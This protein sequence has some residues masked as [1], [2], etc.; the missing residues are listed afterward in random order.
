MRA[1]WSGIR[2][3]PWPMPPESVRGLKS[4]SAVQMSEGARASYS[5]NSCAILS[6]EYMIVSLRMGYHFTTVEAMCTEE[7]G[8]NFIRMQYKQG[9]PALD[10]RIRRI[11]LISEILTRLGFENSS[12]GDFLDSSI[13]YVGRPLLLER[14]GVLGRLII[15]TKQ[16]D[17]ALQSDDI[18]DWYRDDFLKRLQL[19]R[20]GKD[21]T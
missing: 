6:P 2:A 18:A 20:T 19:V 17:M 21:E 1:F 11:R 13:S 7:P 14:L 8:K 12:Q 5:E 10:R 15:M 3:E 4:R 16:L 9:G